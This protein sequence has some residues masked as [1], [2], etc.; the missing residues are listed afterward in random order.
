M[1][2]WHGARR[3]TFAARLVRFSTQGFLSADPVLRNLT[4]GGSGQEYVVRTIVARGAEEAAAPFVDDAPVAHG[5][6]KNV[7]DAR[8]L[9]AALSCKGGLTRSQKQVC[10]L[11]MLALGIAGLMALDLVL[12]GLSVLFWVVFT[13]LILWRAALLSA[14]LAL[15]RRETSAEIDPQ[16][17]LPVYTVMVAAYNMRR[18]VVLERAATLAT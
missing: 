2:K 1:A 13:T 15:Y 11:I 17:T 14:G 5:R 10:A 12:A 16:G 9:P 4:Y 18:L 8:I 3:K 7:A 6:A